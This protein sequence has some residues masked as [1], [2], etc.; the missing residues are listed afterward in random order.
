MQIATIE[1]AAPQ[2]C[3]CGYLLRTPTERE[4]G[5]CI[6]C[7]MQTALN[8]ARVNEIARAAQTLQALHPIAHTARKAI[9]A[10]QGAVTLSGRKPL[11]GEPPFLCAYDHC[12]ALD[13]IAHAFMQWAYVSARLWLMQ[14]QEEGDQERKT[15][16]TELH[17]W[18]VQQFKRLFTIHLTMQTRLQHFCEEQ[19]I[20]LTFKVIDQALDLTAAPVKRQR[21]QA[22]VSAK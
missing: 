1:T 19:R 15:A 9:V 3:F 10:E 11:D 14:E 8:E 4:K 16:L 2:Q 12:H 20:L 13:Q 17:R 7:G 18:S 6:E 22:T 5:W 21:A